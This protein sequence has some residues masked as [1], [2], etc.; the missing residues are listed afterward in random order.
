MASGS[1][2]LLLDDIASMMDDVAAMSKLAAKK[3]AGVLGDDLALNAQ[4]VVGIKPERELPVIW[5]VAKGSLL[6]KVILVPAALLI[7]AF[8]P[9]AITPLLMIGGG[10]L[11]YE[12]FEKIHHLRHK[13]APN[14]KIAQQDRLHALADTSVDMQVFERNKIKG[15]IR[16][17][18]ILSAEIIAIT[19]GIVAGAP[20]LEQ[21][22]VLS[23]ISVAVTVLVYG[24][25][26]TIVKIDDVGLHLSEQEGMQA[27]IGQGLLWFA[28]YLMKTLSIVGTAA[29]FM[30]GGGILVH[31]LPLLTDW[32]HVISAG[33]TGITH[34]ALGTV[35]N[36]VV[37]VV[38][39]AL[40]FVL[41]N[42]GMS[43]FKR[44]TT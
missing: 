19:L 3:S 39:G 4:Q 18:F 12:G 23:A 6:N 21:F 28:P 20:L 5:A 22:L 34:T 14:K 36:A 42:L 16:T 43:F 35:F 44:S 31:G 30:V 7:S 27:S 17:D 9:W 24:L 8:L 2:L 15:A 41:I 38:A 26:A 32:L 10:F 11:C 37:G 40:L 1:L 25:V 33:F 13:K 29:M